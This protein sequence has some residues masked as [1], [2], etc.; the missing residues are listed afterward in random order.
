M[1]PLLKA[2]DALRTALP[3]FLS[4]RC[5]CREPRCK[6][7]CLTPLLVLAL[8]VQKTK[9]PLLRKAADA[10]RTAPEHEGLR[11]EAAAF[12]KGNP[13]VEDSA[14]FYCLANFEEGLAHMAWW[15]WPEPIRCVRE[16]W[17]AQPWCI[18]YHCNTNMLAL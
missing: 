14:L 13:W 17:M 8:Q 7:C 15:T 5:R 11:S 2:A 10:L 1:P 16:V 3:H 9:V 12:R 4:W 6:C 18:M